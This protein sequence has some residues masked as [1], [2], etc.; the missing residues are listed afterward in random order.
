VVFS[1]H[2]DK[3]FMRIAKG[4]SNGFSLTL[5]VS[6]VFLCF[7]FTGCA[8]PQN[9]RDGQ[10]ALYVP[11]PP[12]S[13][14]AREAP[15]FLIKD[16]DKIFNRIGSPTVTGDKNTSEYIVDPEKPAVYFEE[17]RFTTEKGSYSNLIYRIHFPEVPLSWESW[18]LTSGSNPGLL[19]IYTLDASGELI[20]ITTVH[21]CGCYL[22]FIPTDRMPKDFLPLDWTDGSQDVYGYWLPR[23]INLLHDD[24]MRVAFTIESETHRVGH[25]AVL[26]GYSLD[27]YQP[28]F[29][30]PLYPMQ[31]L[32]QL[33]FE[34]STVSF[35]E[36]E[37]ARKGYVKGSSKILE[38]LFMGWWVFDLQIGED[39]AYSIHDTSG[40]PLYTSLKFWAREASDLKNF[41]AFL[42]YWGWRL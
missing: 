3:V 17:Q 26:S 19:F 32:F 4:A 22:A 28:R 13:I 21:T 9:G 16:V 1:L 14:P 30:L 6:A 33:S 36:D 39:K 2:N 42:K 15:V 23:H 7:L 37:G 5:Y 40:I 35:F 25:V 31:Q 20:L 38:R 24:A 18:H 10:P 8:A 34:G 41:P 11:P 27:R 29:T 12:A